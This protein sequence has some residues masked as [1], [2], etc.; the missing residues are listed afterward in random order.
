MIVL[1][2][3]IVMVVLAVNNRELVQLSFYPLPFTYEAQIFAVFFAGLVIGCGLGWMAQ[4]FA[5]HSRRVEARRLKRRFVAEQVRTD[6]KRRQEEQ[7]AAKMVR[8]QQRDGS[9]VGPHIAI[10]APTR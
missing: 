8:E 7:Q 6:V 1:V 4:V 10:S 5:S 2:G 3:L 9:P